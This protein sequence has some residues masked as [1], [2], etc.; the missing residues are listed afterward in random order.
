MR[1]YYPFIFTIV[2]CFPH[3]P[4]PNQLTENMYPGS[5]SS[6]GAWSNPDLQ[7]STILASDS[8]QMYSQQWS[9]PF[10]SKIN[11]V[12]PSSENSG[13]TALSASTLDNPFGTQLV[14]AGDSFLTHASISSQPDTTSTDNL[15]PYVDPINTPVDFS[16]AFLYNAAS[17]GTGGGSKSPLNT[18]FSEDQD[19]ERPQDSSI[20]PFGHL[21]PLHLAQNGQ[22]ASTE[23][24]NIDNVDSNN[25][26]SSRKSA[27]QALIDGDSPL[28]AIPFSDIIHDIFKAPTFDTPRDLPDIDKAPGQQPLYDPEERVANPKRPDCEDGTYAMCCS[29]GPPRMARSTPAAQVVHRKR[30]CEICMLLLYRLSSSPTTHFVSFPVPK[31]QL[32]QHIKRTVFD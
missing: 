6:K 20:P 12:N 3:Y 29:L 16:G 19:T 13:S 22:V 18:A 24:G 32:L 28:P 27:D 1:L 5:S 8:I 23:S 7:G 14:D 9:M 4:T 10:S 21:N 17:D 25:P 31:S 15:H 2:Y 11:P 26:T 30:M